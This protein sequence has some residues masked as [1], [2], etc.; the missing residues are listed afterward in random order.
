M[1]DYTVHVLPV[2]D[3]REHEESRTCA[4]GPRIDERQ[5]GVLVIH[6]SYDGREFIERA[7]ELAN[8]LGPN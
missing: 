1:D 6:H 8:K 4:C 7:E 2:N 5:D 3:W